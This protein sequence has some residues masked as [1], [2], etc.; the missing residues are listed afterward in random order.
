MSE[1]A[2]AKFSIPSILAIVAAIASFMVGATFGMI[3]AIIVIIF[4]IIGVLISLSAKKRGG[5]VSFA[6]VGAGIIRII[7]AIIKASLYLFR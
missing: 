4:G 2:K 6:S 3:L 1:P 5:I 7:A